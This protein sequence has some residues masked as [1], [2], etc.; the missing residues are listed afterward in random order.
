M[1]GIVV[2]LWRWPVAGMAGES[3]PSVRVDAYG[4]G[5]D[6]VHFVLGDGTPLELEGW[7]AAYPFN[8][9]AN[10]DPASPPLAIV[11]SPRGRAFRWGDPRLRWALEDA[12]GRPVELCRDLERRPDFLVVAGPAAPPALRANVRVDIELAGISA[13]AFAG[14]ARVRLLEEPREGAARARPVAAGRVA[15]GGSVSIL[16]S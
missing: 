14:G 11:T 16:A 5:G 9:G 8:I 6:R 7:S 10:V 13:L 12:L 15:V 4:V 1:D 3:M 2:A